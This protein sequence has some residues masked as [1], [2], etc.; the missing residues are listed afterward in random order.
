MYRN[1][2]DL[3]E[4]V[5]TLRVRG[6]FLSRLIRDGIGIRSID[7]SGAW[8]DGDVNLIG[9]D[10]RFP[11]HITNSIIS[12][13]FKGFGGK[14]EH[15]NLQSTSLLSFQADG[16]TISGSLF[17]RKGFEA[18]EDVRIVSARI[19]GSIDLGESKFFAA[20]DEVALFLAYTTV[21][22]TAHIND[23]R[24]HG[25]SQLNDMKVERNVDLHGTNII[26]ESCS[27]LFD[28]I[29]VGGSIKIGTGFACTDP[30]QMNRARI[31][32]DL[33]FSG[34]IFS[35]NGYSK[36]A[37]IVDG[38]RI[39]GVLFVRGARLIKGALNFAYSHANVVS[40]LDLTAW[41]QATE[42]RLDG[43]TYDRIDG[44]I[45]VP[46]RVVWLDKIESYGDNS[47]FAQP[48]EQ[49][50][51]TLNN[52]GY[53][54]EARSVATEKERRIG[55]GRV[56]PSLERRAW[57]CLFGLIAGFGYE[58][59]RVVKLMIATWLISSLVYLWAD[60]KAAIS[61]SNA[62]IF[63]N[64]SI[65]RDCG[66]TKQRATT[67]KATTG[68]A[69]WTVCGSVPQEYTTFNALFYSL[70]L[71]LPL[72]DLQQ[73]RDWSPTVTEPDGVTMLVPGAI[74]RFTMWAE[75]LLGWFFSLIFVAALT[76]LTKNH[77]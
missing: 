76:G 47:F 29:D 13:N 17:L 45:D 35:S 24:I 8:I 65:A 73:D 39:D 72:V 31:G 54:L 46:K 42:L 66:W 18:I 40:D 2:L 7:I 14:F 70:D 5:A 36:Y 6:E 37:I 20:E 16:C 52:L 77:E 67:D 32:R 63:N 49:L 74:A 1:S 53:K 33:D 4:V 19:D 30:I 59:F 55:K 62:L 75:I 27:I 34:G 61:P 71:I 26:T 69:R 22:G 12:G 56:I 68:K 9:A 58:P 64:E 38:S 60:Q 41:M 51:K 15:L 23:C 43:F 48:W 10:I 50:S 57:H 44:D 11:L 28:A 25:L 21:G 3:H